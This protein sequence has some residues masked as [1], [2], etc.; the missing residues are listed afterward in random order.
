MITTTQSPRRQAVIFLILAAVLWSSSGLLIKVM[1]WQPLSI[2]AGRSIIAAL[3][4]VIYL[5]RLRLRRDVRFRWSPSLAVGAVAFLGTQALFITATKMTTAANAIFL[6]YTAPV[7][8]V[9]LGYVWLGE[10]PERAD[11]F[12]MTVILLGL[13]FFFG[14]KLS[15]E[16]TTGNVLAILSG[17]AMAVMTVSMRRI[18]RSRVGKGASPKAR[19][20]SPTSPAYATLLGYALGAIL[21]LP[22]LMQETLTP[23][24]LGII[25]FLGLFQIGLAFLLYAAAIQHVQALEATLILTLE[26]ILNPIWVFLVI[27]EAPGPMAMLGSALVIA[28]VATRALIS[29]RAGESA[30]RP[31]P[32]RPRAAGD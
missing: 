15:F 27:G 31:K 13:L 9:V 23:Q 1:D 7:Y 16:G 3:V 2:L 26:P 21:G 6:Q 30:S 22:S 17:V 19:D 14:D 24:S 18:G 29:A 20:P 8:V 5:R 11:W 10:Q 28:A 25:A 4:Y 32:L 12:A